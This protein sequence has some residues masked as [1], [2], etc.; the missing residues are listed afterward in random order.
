MNI[1]ISRLSHTNIWN[2]RI[3]GHKI[4]GWEEAAKRKREIGRLMGYFSHSDVDLSQRTRYP[5]VTQLDRAII[6]ARRKKEVTFCGIM[7]FPI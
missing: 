7:L 3:F 1:N 2:E 4:L 5:Q 6:G